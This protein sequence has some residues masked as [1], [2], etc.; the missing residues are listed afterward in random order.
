MDHHAE[1]GKRLRHDAHAALEGLIDIGWLKVQKDQYL[2]RLDREVDAI[3]NAG[4]A[5]NFL[6]VSE[7]VNEARARGIPLGPGL[8]STPSS[9]VAYAL[10]IHE[11]DPIRYGLFFERF[12]SPSS[13]Q[14]P[15]FGVSVGDQRANDIVDIVINKYSGKVHTRVVQDTPIQMWDVEY[16]IGD[17]LQTIDLALSKA[18]TLSQECLASIREND[19]KV[20]IDEIPLDDSRVFNNLSEGVFDNHFDFDRITSSPRSDLP[21]FIKRLK[22]RNLMELSDALTLFRSGAIKAGLADEYIASKLGVKPVKSVLPPFDNILSET[23]GMIIY[24]EQIMNIACDIGMFSFS[25][26]NLLRKV[27]GK[28]IYPDIETFKMS[29]LKGA[30]TNNIPID[31]SN[32]IWGQMIY[33]SSY[34]LNKSHAISSALELYRL[35]YLKTLQGAFDG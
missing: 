30:G 34:A 11:I 10:G 15:R 17:R 4:F 14:A 2:R 32:Y 28:K 13:N 18:V 9:L 21:S 26:A 6:V 22:P 27:L 35:E 31:I 12:F 5:L 3:C 20:F 8:G 19:N 24:Q 23:Y 33:Y 29:F 1:A 25:D 16:L 7:I